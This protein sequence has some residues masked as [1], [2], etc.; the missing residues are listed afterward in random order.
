MAAT[1]EVAVDLAGTLDMVR[2]Q[3]AALDA[4]ID[5]QETE[6]GK[7]KARRRKLEAGVKSFEAANDPDI[8]PVRRPG[9]RPAE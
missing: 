9:R 7:L 2:E 1:D 4:E 8:E 3:I 5:R 6:L